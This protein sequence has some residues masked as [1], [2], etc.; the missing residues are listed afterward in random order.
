MSRVADASPH[1]DEDPDGAVVEQIADVT[2]SMGDGRIIGVGGDTQD[3]PN[4]AGFAQAVGVG[5]ESV[6]STLVCR[7][8]DQVRL[9]P[10]SR[11]GGALLL[12]THPGYGNG[13]HGAQIWTRTLLGLFG[14]GVVAHVLVGG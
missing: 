13:R 1:R 12:C 4:I 9:F 2:D 5:E 14:S 10:H 7:R 8:A 11:L 6:L 3:E